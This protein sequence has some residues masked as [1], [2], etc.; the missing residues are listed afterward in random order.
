MRRLNENLVTN[1]VAKAAAHM[2]QLMVLQLSLNFQNLIIEPG[3]VSIWEVCCSPTSSLTS[4]CVKEQL[5][6]QRINL[7]NCFDLDKAST[8]EAISTL[9]WQKRPN[10]IWT[11]MRCT[12]WCPWNA[13][14][15]DSVERKA[16]L[17]TRRRRE[18]LALR[19][20]VN[21]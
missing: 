16:E 10:G 7:A 3:Q 19:R 15:Y 8:Y 14:N 5:K 13:L 12:V 20:L 2:I 6:C 1:K 21:G 17:E 4:A 11:S 9:Y 18:R